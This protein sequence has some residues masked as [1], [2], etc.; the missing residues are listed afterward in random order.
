[1]CD[2]ACGSQSKNKDEQSLCTHEMSGLEP[3]SQSDE[4]VVPPLLH[5]GFKML[6]KNPVQQIL[7]LL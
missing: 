2:L 5:A 6:A 7:R 3:F 4:G 1:M